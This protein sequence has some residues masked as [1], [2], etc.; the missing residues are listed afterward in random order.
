MTSAAAFDLSARP[1]PRLQPTTLPPG[2]RR[3]ARPALRVI[4]GGRAPGR[5]AQQLVYR[6]RRIAAVLL[7]AAAILAVYVLASAVLGRT[8]G[9]GT[10]VPT[11]GDPSVHIV[12]P[13]ETLWSIAGGLNPDGD[14]RLTVDQLVGLNGGAPIQVGQQL[15]VP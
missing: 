7:L 6:R 13:G 14:V 4:E 12:Q 5:S 1:L 8:A 2:P 10:P 11:A 9:G 15:L 3:P